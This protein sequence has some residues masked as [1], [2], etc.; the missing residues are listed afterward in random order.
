MQ[1]IISKSKQK[2]WFGLQIELNCFT[3]NRSTLPANIAAFIQPVN[4]DNF[5]ETDLRKQKNLDSILCQVRCKIEQKTDS[6]S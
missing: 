1:I 6:T 2:T 5:H 4:I 3:Q